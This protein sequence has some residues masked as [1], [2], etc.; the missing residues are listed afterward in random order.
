MHYGSVDYTA[1][2]LVYPDIW[3]I[4]AD[5]AYLPNILYYLFLISFSFF[6]A[7]QLHNYTHLFLF[8]YTFHAL[9]HYL[10]SIF[11]SL[12]TKHTT[13]KCDCFI[14]WVTYNPLYILYF[15]H[16]LL[17]MNRHFELIFPEFQ[18]C[19][20]CS[21]VCLLLGFLRGLPENWRQRTIVI[22]RWGGIVESES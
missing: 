9:Q 10:P 18:I 6:P 7:C 17:I 13:Y 19:Y 16:L 11:I 12:I 8:H 5:D 20:V 4:F 22:I 21:L 1:L 15:K 2:V 14:T 3:M